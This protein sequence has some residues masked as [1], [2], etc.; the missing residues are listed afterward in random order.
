MN[1][2]QNYYQQPQ[3][4]DHHYYSNNYNNQHNDTANSHRINKRP[5]KQLYVPRGRRSGGKSSF[6]ASS[7]ACRDYEANSRAPS[8]A[9]SISSVVSEF[10]G[11]NRYQRYTGGRSD[12]HYHDDVND[13]IYIR[14]PSMEKSG[15]FSRESTPG[16]SRNKPNRFS[17]ETLQFIGKC[18]DKELE[19]PNIKPLN[20]ENDWD[21]GSNSSLVSLNDKP[22]NNYRNNRNV[23]KS[24]TPSRENSIHCKENVMYPVESSPRTRRNKRNRKRRSHSRD[25]STESERGF[26]YSDK[27][28]IDVYN[29]KHSNDIRFNEKVFVNSNYSNRFDNSNR[30]IKNYERDNSQNVSRSNS[31]NSSRERT[32]SHDWRNVG[33]S[34]PETPI[35]KNEASPKNKHQRRHSIGRPPSGRHG[36]LPNIL[37]LSNVSSENRLR[38]ITNTCPIESNVNGHNTP[39]RTELNRPNHFDDVNKVVSHNSNESNDKCKIECNTE[40]NKNQT[41]PVLSNECMSNV[42]D[43][44]QNLQVCNTQANY[45]INQTLNSSQSLHVELENSSSNSFIENKTNHSNDTSPVEELSSLNLESKVI[46]AVEPGKIKKRVKNNT[47]KP[48]RPP[49]MDI[50]SANNPESPVSTDVTQN[51]ETTTL[52]SGN[53]KN[54]KKFSFN[55]ADVTDEDSWENLYKDDDDDDCVQNS[56]LKEEINDAI[57]EVELVKPASDYYDFKGDEPNMK[58]EDYMHVI[59]LYDFPSSFKTLDLMT[60]FSSYQ[61]SGLDI[62]WVDDTHALGV[63]A[64]GMVGKYIIIAVIFYLEYYLFKPIYEASLFLSVT[65]DC[66]L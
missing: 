3:P 65:I 10:S 52:N 43:S 53:K 4:P 2:Q 17:R 38:N 6:N 11:R 5:D 29:N 40:T 9:N 18:I 7:P 35:K 57:G 59:E 44:M 41:S 32:P 51:N 45:N 58:D 55:W 66:W 1:Q 46:Q 62:K 64:T 25:Q 49:S 61:D 37:D 42:Q 60:I 21:K 47:A 63:F 39:K 36:S 19:D 50:D 20:H 13:R 23:S 56:S 24:P 30:Y 8:P 48:Y 33:G 54:A 14:P 12:G 31:R 28:E 27:K 34:N 16:V 22:R 26:N 15:E